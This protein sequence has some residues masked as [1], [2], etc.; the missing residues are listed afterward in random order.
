[1]KKKVKAKAKA[2]KR[3]KV[4]AKNKPRRAKKIIRLAQKKSR[5]KKAKMAP[6]AAKKV[7]RIMGHGQFTVDARTLKRLNDID[8]EL[9]EMVA[10]EKADDVGFKKK[11]AELNQITIKHGKAVEPGEI[12][13]SDI[14]L[15]SADLSVDEA[16]KLFVGEGVIPEN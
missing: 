12:V 14:I 15:P 13:R 1:M 9:V 8:S 2:R 5:P 11:L 4:V 10:S 16:K 6:A 7:V 3:A